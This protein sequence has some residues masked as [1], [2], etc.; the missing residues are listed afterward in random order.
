MTDT[1]PDVAVGATATPVRPTPPPV[2]PRRRRGVAGSVRRQEALWGYAMIAPVGLGLAIFYLWPVAQTAYFSFTE[3]G[4]FGGHEWT[5]AANYRRLVNDP[6]VRQALLNTLIYTA[7]GMFGIPLAIVFAALLNR[8]RLRG[9]SLYR[10]LFFLP[11]VTMPVAVA[12]IWRWLYNG[13]FGLINYVLSVF[14]VAGPHWIA[15]R[16]TALYALVVIGIWAG[17]GY[18]IV[19]FLAGMQAIPGEYYEAAS[20]DGA[21]PVAQFFRITVPLLSP[22]IF[23]VS[24]ISVIGSLQLFDLVYVMGGGGQTARTNPAFPRIQTVV[25][26]FYDK[27]FYTNDRGYAAT[28]VMG[29]LVLIISLTL[30]QFRL[31][32]RWVHYE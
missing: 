1:Q 22:T 16:H 15:E 29:L 31:Q 20:I 32:K 26:L 10:T 13:D 11:V 3:W 17:I 30:A 19:L 2:A 28:I 6:E 12:M 25:Y 4:P 7:L 8:R 14:G 24:V 23:F 27:A 9:V 21:S 18:N 5:G